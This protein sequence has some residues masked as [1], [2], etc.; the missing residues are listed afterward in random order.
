MKL[1]QKTKLASLVALTTAAIAAGANAAELEEVVVMATPIKDAQAASLEAKRLANNVVDVIAAD[2]IGRFPDQ[3]MADS[4]GRVP[5]MAIERD[6]G[7][8]RYVNFRGTPF[9]W[10][11]IGFNGIDIPGAENG[12]IPRF[13]SFP[14]TITSSVNVNKAVL[15]SMPGEAVAGYVDIKTFNP[16]DREG[17]SADL[18]LGAGTQSLGS[19]DI[20]RQSLRLSFSND[21][22]GVM[23]FAS[24]NT[25]HQIT[26]NQEP[27]YAEV[28]GSVE[29]TKI[30]Y[31]SYKVERKDAAHGAHVEYRADD[32][33]TRIFADYLYS[34]FVDLEERNHFDFK[35]DPATQVATI[36]DHLLEYGRYDNSSKV[37][38]LGADFMLD[39]WSLEARYNNTKTEFNTFLPIIY[40]IP[41]A[42]QTTGSYDFTNL[43]NV[44][45]DLDSP[46]SD[47]TFMNLS[48]LFDTPLNIDADVFKL[49][50]T[51]TF[52]DTEFAAGVQMT[53]RKAN[54]FVGTGGSIFG[55]SPAF[56]STLNPDDYR[57]S[58]P[59]YFNS[60]NSLGETYFDNI[61]LRTDWEQAVG[62]LRL[63]ATDSTRIAINEDIDA[64]YAMSTQT[65][66]WGNVVLGLRIEKTKYSS[67]GTIE[68]SAVTVSDSFTNVLPSIHVNYDVTDDVKARFS[69]TTGVNRPTYN[70]WRASGSIDPVNQEVSG[71]N[72]ALQAE[73]SMGFDAALE[74][75]FADA[76]L[77][78]MSIFQRNVDNVIYEGTSKIDGSLYGSNFSG[79]WDLS[80][81]VNGSDGKLQ[82]LELNFIGQGA[83]ISESLAGFGVSLNT[84][85]LD[86]E[87]KQL[88][89][90]V[91]GMPGTSDMMYNASLFFE[92]YGL[93]VRLNYQYRDE[94]ISPIEDPSEV[95]GATKR[96]DLNA[97][98]QLPWDLNGASA[99]VYLN[100]NNLTD[101]VDVRYD[102]NHF[103]NQVESYG[104][105]YLVGLRISY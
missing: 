105:R 52:G 102:A 24:G 11:A 19:G 44:V 59:W 86:A 8:A 41:I 64:A 80:G 98:Y 29:L 87:F 4:L 72:P 61:G 51:K 84:T 89:G 65:T 74:Y 14:S 99:T 16:F 91:V 55:G 21:N 15:A 90:T 88:D 10:T 56:P 33:T 39:E 12:R 36:K 5:G 77:L 54:G 104:P 42:N 93:S 37:S 34:E 79:Q 58:Q 62:S 82:G 32:Q 47:T 94:W 60:N 83:E 22:F 30:R 1:F 97:M 53:S 69:F 96:L 73:K 3:N 7:Q 17:F 81:Y 70:E 9:R 63:S 85:L 57:T 67:E 78:S 46:I 20:S 2:T 66:D 25:R 27:G 35:M 68:G 71:G 103:A 75:Y 18:D 101:E 38:T 100:A 13:D 45:M 28:D 26:D 31:A 40:R 43:T 92:D 49:D 50:A 6:Q 23:A 95:W 48:Y 76:S